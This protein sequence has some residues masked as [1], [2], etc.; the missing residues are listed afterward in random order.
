VIAMVPSL[1]RPT[2]G[3]E[4]SKEGVVFSHS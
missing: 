2:L 3:F 4:F 1:Q